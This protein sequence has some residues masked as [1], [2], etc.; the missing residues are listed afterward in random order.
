VAKTVRASGRTESGR[1]VRLL[2]RTEMFVGTNPPLPFILSSTSP[3]PGVFGI[4]RPVLIWPEFLS[5]HLSDQHIEAILAHELSHV[6]RHDNLTAALHMFVEAVFWFYPI[7]WWLGGR[8]MSER[9]LACDEAVI[10][11]GR[12]R[13][14]YAES[15]LRTCERCVQ[16][17]VACVAGI[18]RSNLSQRME[19]IMKAHSVP[20]MAAWKRLALG[21]AVF[22]LV[23]LPIAY[24]MGSGRPARAQ[25]DPTFPSQGAPSFQSASIQINTSGL[26]T[27]QALGFP[28]EGRF[29]ASNV[30]L[31]ELIK[32]VYGHEFLGRDRVV[33]GPEWV[34][35]ERF[36]VSAQ[37]AG[38]PLPDVRQLM[39]RTL[40]A[41][42]FRLAVHVGHRD[43]SAYALTVSAADPNSTALHRSA[44]TCPEPGAPPPPPPPPGISP[45]ATLCGVRPEADALT[46]DA[47]KMWQ[48]ALL[49]GP[50]VGRTV[51]DRTGLEGR[52]NFTVDW[53]GVPQAGPDLTA[54]TANRRIALM[55]ALRDQLGLE[56]VPETAN[57]P[58]LAIDAAERPALNQ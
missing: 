48:L 11:G 9:E 25:S 8:L 3:E 2:R 27:A 33:G 12:D 4:I 16:R 51:V 39:V 46:G 32:A 20:P 5:A 29:F 24:G 58:I 35:S 26:S 7:V 36:D 28:P 53:S 41:E 57:I 1:E 31:L 37:A 47:A 14:V 44:A 6:R 42:R 45:F 38:D 50:R 40:L 34:R 23:V 43:V 55:T 49:L 15:I 30:S 18:G 21:A 54:Q 19:V 13:R 10:R 56:L 17:P 22:P 52:F